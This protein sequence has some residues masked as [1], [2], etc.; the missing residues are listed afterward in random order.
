MRNK[1][2]IPLLIVTAFFIGC[3]KTVD[4][5]PD[6]IVENDTVPQVNIEWPSLADTPW[7]MYHHDPQSTGRSQY[8]GPQNGTIS[9]INLPLFSTM[10]GTSIGYNKTAFLPASDFSYS[11]L[12][13]FNYAGTPIWS[14]SVLG[15]YTTPLISSDSSIYVASQNKIFIALNHNGDTLWTTPISIMYSRGI[16][17]DKKGNLYLIERS[18]NSIN[19]LKVLD[20]NGN[21]LWTLKDDRITET[22]YNIPTFSP[23]GNTVYI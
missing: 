12:Y 18:D 8:R 15:S 19:S 14:K 23:D 16:N 20:E 3:D 4:P 2:L 10:S 17:I 21:L 1:I 22:Y 11:L 7:P 6:P 5:P 13:A 9:H